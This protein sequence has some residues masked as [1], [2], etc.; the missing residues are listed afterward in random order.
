M[1]FKESRGQVFVK[2]Q[3]DRFLNLRMNESKNL[4][5][6][7][8]LSP[9]FSDVFRNFPRYCSKR[10]CRLK[11][12]FLV[13]TRPTKQFEFPELCRDSAECKQAY[14]CFRCSIA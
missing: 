6:W 14:F 11:S 3:G 4:S 12:L 10:F 9:C 7:F 1:E 13:A 8:S 5:P 2:N